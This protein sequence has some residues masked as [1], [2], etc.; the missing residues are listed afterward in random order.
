ME[1]ALRIAEAEQGSRGGGREMAE[2]SAVGAEFVEFE[3]GDEIGPGLSE[4][5]VERAGF[6]VS[7]EDNEDRAGSGRVCR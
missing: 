2:P 4:V 7:T 3:G 6:G 1:R 5:E